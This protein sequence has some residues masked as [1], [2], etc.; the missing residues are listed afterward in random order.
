VI[1]LCVLPAKLPP[2]PTQQGPVSIERVHSNHALALSEAGL[3]ACDTVQ[4]WLGKTLCPTS[5]RAAQQTISQ[6]EESRA[7]GY[8]LCYLMMFD[9]QCLGMGIINYIHPIHGNANLG[10]WLVPNARGQGLATLLCQR[11]IRLAFS[12]I[13]L[14]R[15]ELYIEPENHASIALARKIGAVKEGLCRNRVFG[16]DALLYAI[17][18]D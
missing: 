13:E 4:P 12:Q 6:L 7:N 2:I 10:Y 3:R 15:V 9:Q 18:E 14:S 8:G 17:V 11:L 1:D 5:L 16:R